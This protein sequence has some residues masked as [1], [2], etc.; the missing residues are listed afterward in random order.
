MNTPLI[1]TISRQLGSGGEYIGQQLA[2]Q[3]Q[4][5]YID[6]RLIS[7][8]AKELS[9]PEDEVAARE[10]QIQSLWK[11]FTQSSSFNSNMDIPAFLKYPPTDYQL[12]TVESDIIKKIA[13]EGSAIIM[14]RCGFH[15]LKGRPNCVNIFLYADKEVRA[16][17][18]A[19]ENSVAQDKAMEMIVESDRKRA[20]YIEAFTKKNWTDAAVYD[21]SVNTG[22]LGLNKTIDLILNYLDV[23]K[24]NTN[25]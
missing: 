9:V 1:I 3:L 19:E 4:I 16:K 13:K 22:K 2:G 25:Q 7:E 15:V 6:R 14:G 20:Q 23:M 5:Q 8:V 10:E 21:L 17:R 24:R 18:V 12:F 11:A